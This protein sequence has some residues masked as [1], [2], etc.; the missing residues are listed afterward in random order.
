MRNRGEKKQKT[1]TRCI[2][3]V[4]NNEQ[5]KRGP[6]SFL[7]A[8]HSLIYA[9]AYI[10]GK[11]GMLECAN[12]YANKHGGKL[13]REFDVIDDESH[14]INDCKLNENINRRSNTEKIIFDDIHCND[15]QKILVVV[16]CILVV[17]DLERGR[18]VIRTVAE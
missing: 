11:Y 10:M 5:Y 12:N 15:S 18:N 16:R 17:W 13:C 1:K 14:E 8:H 6:D 2:E 7:T 4:I 3:K 9:K